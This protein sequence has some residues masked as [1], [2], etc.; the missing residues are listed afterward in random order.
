MVQARIC[1]PPSM[2]E[3]E[4]HYDGPEGTVPFTLNCYKRIFF[5]SIALK[6]LVFRSFMSIFKVLTVF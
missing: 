3:G 2:E 4:E 5:D 6:F 1:Y